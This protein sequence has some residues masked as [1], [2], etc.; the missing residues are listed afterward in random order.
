RLLGLRDDENTEKE[1]RRAREQVLAAGIARLDEYCTDV[2][3]PISVHHWRALLDDELQ[4]LKDEDLEQ[5]RRA[6]AR[7]DVATDV[8]RAAPERRPA[9]LL[10]LRTGGAINDKPYRDLQLELDRANS[11]PREELAVG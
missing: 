10:A 3:C 2:S 8:P 11:R 9:A 6:R 7:V 5:R 1:V 4:S